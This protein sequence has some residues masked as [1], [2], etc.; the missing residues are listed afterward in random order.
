MTLCSIYAR[1]STDLQSEAS[2]EDQVRLCREKA[3]RE[4]WGIYEIYAD[5]AVSGASLIRPGIQQLMA[6]A[7]KFQIVLT[8]SLDRLSRDQ[9][10]VAG[11]YKRLKFADT[12]IITLSEGEI[13]ELHIGLT[14]TMSALYLKNLADKTRRGQR[15]R[16][17]AGKIGG[18][19][20][21]GYN[22]VK[23]FAENG[24]LIRGDRAINPEQA[25][26]V[27]RIFT[28]YA[29]GFF[30]PVDSGAVEQGRHSRT[31][32]SGLGRQHNSRTPPTRNGDPQQ[33]ALHRPDRLE[34]APLCERP[35]Q[36][37]ARVPAQPG[38]PVDI[39]GRSAP[40]HHP[41]RA[42]ASRQGQAGRFQSQHSA[43][44]LGEAPA[45]KPSSPG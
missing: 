26:I 40:P 42:V 28:E 30:S 11:L 24:D 9:E 16:V 15:G 1:Y 22:V 18:G 45:R 25:A 13:S 32:R 39:Q 41:G 6:D 35:E 19:N 20:S 5:A 3:D 29:E 7:G 38:K 17:E 8:E 34:Q 43:Y 23:R 44:P 10:D 37:P 4:G 27:V 36:R 12:K 21:Y 14:G 33:C 2:I 31:R